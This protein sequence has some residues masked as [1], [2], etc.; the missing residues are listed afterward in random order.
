MTQHMKRILIYIIL[1]CA[2]CKAKAQ[3][4]AVPQLPP[5]G[6]S[7]KQQLWNIAVTNPGP[8]LVNIHIG[9]T[10][11]T[12]STGQQVLSATTRMISIPPG[13]TI[14]DAAQLAPIQ[15][16]STSTAYVIDPGPYGL[17]PVGSFDICYHFFQHIADNIQDVLEVCQ[18]IDIEPLG[19]PQLVYPFDQT[20]IEETNPL[21]RWLPPV[22]L[23]LFANLNYDFILVALNPN[24]SAADAMQQNLPFFQRSGVSDPALF[25][26]SAAPALQYDQSYAWRIVAKSN[27]EAVGASEIWQFTLKQYQA[28]NMA[29]VKELPF[30]RFKKEPDGYA[31][32]FN[33]LKFNYV[34]ETID[35]TWN[36]RVTDLSVA[37][38][39]TL[40]LAMDT[41]PLRPGQNMVIYPASGIS[42]FQDRH[43][44]LLELIN[45]AEEK[46]RLR[47]QYR[48][49][50]EPLNQN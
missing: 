36:V 33:D 27:G 34:N 44:Y 46:W 41:I 7:Y 40:Q 28:L 30:A 39:D 4:Q 26:T 25:Y 1:I 2:A 35:T 38:S 10:M 5:A 9:L 3:L 11:T 12:E 29:G 42:F 24:Q 47:F 32:F 18:P 6:L 23:N 16:N 21:F 45:S 48:K 14:L 50:E 22:P 31:L 20:A 8:A 17:L 49:S 37:G 15:Y 19:P 13:T 43:F